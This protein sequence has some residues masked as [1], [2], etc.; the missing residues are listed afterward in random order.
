MPT[1]EP[2]PADAVALCR[3][4]FGLEDLPP[5]GPWVPVERLI[6]F[7]TAL[8]KEQGYLCFL[9]CAATHFPATATEPE[10]LLVA[11]RLR[12]LG[13]GEGA[14]A[15]KETNTLAF[16]VKISPE[17]ELP[18]LSALWAGADWQEREQHDLVGVRFTGH[19]DLRR[20]MLPEDWQGH[21]LRR[22][23]AIDTR[24]EPWR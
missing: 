1:S 20:I 2:F 24:C 6:E 5:E 22:D 18:S 3:E 16:R 10:H 21:P 8:K 13:I 17:Q 4:R 12:R 9:Y 11:W 15:R 19:P 14:G 7:A 23:Y